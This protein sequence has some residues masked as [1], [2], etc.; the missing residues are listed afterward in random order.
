MRGF[1]LYLAALLVLLAASASA[2]T[3]QIAPHASKTLQ[4]QYSADVAGETLF[5]D[6]NASPGFI[7]YD[8]LT[9]S[10]MATWQVHQVYPLPSATNR[11][12]PSFSLQAT[13]KLAGIEFDLIETGFAYWGGTGR[14]TG[15][16][17]FVQSGT[18]TETTY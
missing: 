8:G 6:M 7:Q 15:V 2:Q 5:I 13:C 9:C 18:I 10:P 14:T 3:A 12:Q 16:Y 17:Y 4:Y 11:T 1:N